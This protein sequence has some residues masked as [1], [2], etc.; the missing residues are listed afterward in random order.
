MS[1]LQVFVAL[2]LALAWFAWKVSS[3]TGERK[4][5][6]LWRGMSFMLVALGLNKLLEGSLANAGRRIAVAQGWYGE[7]Q[8]FQLWFILIVAVLWLAA[9]TG[10]MISARRAPVATRLALLGIAML[11]AFALIRDVSLHQIDALIGVQVIGFKLNWIIELAG[12]ALIVLVSAWRWS[13]AL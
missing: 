6:A 7:R 12:I 4:E 11:I 2:Y 9:A 1:V 8:I 13:R 10:L 3:A 5:G